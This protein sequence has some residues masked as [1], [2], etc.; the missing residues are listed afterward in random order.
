MIYT[1]P[2]SW[3][4]I[5]GG[6]IDEF[7]LTWMY[8]FGLAYFFVGIY[9]KKFTIKKDFFNIILIVL[10]IESFVPLVAANDFVGGLPDFLMI[11][12]FAVLVFISY[13]SGEK[14]SDSDIKTLIN[15]FIFINLISAIVIM[16]QYFTYQYT[17][18]I[19]FK[20]NI[21]GTYA[22]SKMQ[23]GGQL[24][25]EDASSATIMLACAVLLALFNGK[26]SKINYI[27]AL[28]ILVGLALTA[29][30]TGAIA[31][32]V[33]LPIYFICAYKGLKRIIA[34]LL[35]AIFSFML[36]T[37]LTM[38]RPVDDITQLFDDNNRFVDYEKA[39]IIFEQNPL[40]VGYGDKYIASLTGHTI[41]HNTILRWLDIG[42]LI[43]PLLLV[44]IIIKSTFASWYM[45]EN[46]GIFWSMIC[47]IIGMNF[48]PDIL[49]ARFIVIL[50]V[51]ALI[52]QKGILKIGDDKNEESIDCSSNI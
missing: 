28:V 15:D 23:V 12:F 47:T 9:K 22:V 6:P 43:L 33:V 10:L 30:R 27:Y 44:A 51:L 11:I 42:G 29:R 18:K 5:F 36:I 32:L 39:I 50:C 26:K 38:S 31:L 2:Y 1:L 34:I 16:F 21:E 37:M 3:S 46:R 8:V 25:F 49:N 24:L 7:P 41:P 40:G 13:N 35:M 48:I 45:R 20:M 17:G 19:F 52:H 4:N 14:I